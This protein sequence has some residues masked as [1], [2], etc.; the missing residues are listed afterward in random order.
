MSRWRVAIDVE[1]TTDEAA[2]LRHVLPRLLTEAGYVTVSS[3]T[4]AQ[5]WLVESPRP[6][7]FQ[8]RAYVRES[9]HIGRTR[10]KRLGRGPEA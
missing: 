10:F 2:Q 6:G 4:T 5:A 3:T 8:E 7:V 9:E 1:A